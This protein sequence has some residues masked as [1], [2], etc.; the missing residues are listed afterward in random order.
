MDTSGYVPL[1]ILRKLPYESRIPENDEED[2]ELFREDVA[3]LP[4]FGKW[5]IPFSDNAIPLPNHPL[6]DM[7]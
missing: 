2:W 5:G 7:G 1:E 6:L 3:E 4:A